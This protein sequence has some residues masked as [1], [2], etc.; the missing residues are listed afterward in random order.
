MSNPDESHDNERESGGLH[1]IDVEDRLVEGAVA[2]ASIDSKVSALSFSPPPKTVELQAQIS[3]ETEMEVGS[4]NPSPLHGIGAVGENPTNPVLGRLSGTKRKLSP[5][6][7]G[8]KE[9]LAVSSST[10]TQRDSK[11]EQSFD[12]QLAA[13]FITATNTN[14]RAACYSKPDPKGAQTT[15]FA[16][17]ATSKISAAAEKAASKSLAE[18][19][20]DL[21]EATSQ[22]TSSQQQS[23][24]SVVDDRPIS[25][26]STTSS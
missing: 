6:K 8:N 18:F 16:F 9:N 17:G 2:L 5:E 4:G 11:V 12:E 15:G 7:T 10:S 13:V 1:Q 23:E 20:A 21:P 19:A 26:T 14:S 25:K 22:S 3:K 24:M